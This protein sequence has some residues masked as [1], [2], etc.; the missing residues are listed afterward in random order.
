MGQSF[1]RSFEHIPYTM[2]WKDPFLGWVEDFTP[3]RA[4]SRLANYIAGGR[5][6]AGDWS[7][8]TAWLMY[9]QLKVCD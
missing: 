3:K 8:A 6:Y 1:A 9:K 7:R 4:A 5:N 2:G